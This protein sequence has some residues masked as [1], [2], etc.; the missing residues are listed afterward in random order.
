MKLLFVVPP[1]ITTVVSAN[2]RP[3]RARASARSRPWATVWALIESKPGARLSLL[4]LRRDGCVRLGAPTD[5]VKA[6][7]HA[8]GRALGRG[9]HAGHAEVDGL[10]FSSRL[11]GAHFYAVF[12]R[13]IGKLDATHSGMLPDHPGLARVLS[14]YS[15]KLIVP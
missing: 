14:R 15:I 10:L 13:A 5:A 1:S 6:R 8:A 7:N 12:D 11:T 3:S 4:D 9:I 2:A